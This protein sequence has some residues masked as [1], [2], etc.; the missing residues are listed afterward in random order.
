MIAAQ[1]DKQQTEQLLAETVEVVRQV[2]SPGF[3]DVT[4]EE[5][6]ELVNYNQEN[7][8]EDLLEEDNMEGDHI[9]Q[10]E[11][12]Q[13]QLQPRE[14]AEGLLEAEGEADE[15][16]EPM[17]DAE[18]DMD[19]DFS[20]FIR[21][22]M[23]D[24]E[25]QHRVELL[26]QRLEEEE[27]QNGGDSVGGGG[28][29]GG[30]G[31]S[32]SC[33]SSAKVEAL[34][35]TS[36][37]SYKTD[38][39]E[40]DDDDSDSDEVSDNT[41]DPTETEDVPDVSATSVEHDDALIPTGKC[42]RDGDIAVKPKS[43]VEYNKIKK[44]DVSDQMSKQQHYLVEAEGQKRTSRKRC[45]SCYKMTSINEGSKVASKKAKKVSTLEPKAIIVECSKG[46]L[47][48]WSERVSPRKVLRLDY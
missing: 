12:Q 26:R 30:G 46:A 27:M 28:V 9:E 33:S 44:G 34:L 10:P 22:Q 14:V 24:V 36:D 6:L 25:R 13:Q 38:E 41:D 3:A 4:R 20:G 5:M 8:T 40:S 32:S 19:E 45:V 2:R 17:E 48:P 18:L 11:Q 42:A 15:G 43:V 16:A 29:S 7:N 39:S 31:D 37:S 47:G 1:E 21:E 35:D 23:A